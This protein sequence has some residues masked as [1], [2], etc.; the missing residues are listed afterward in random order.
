MLRS[1]GFISLLGF[2]ACNSNVPK[3]V[4]RKPQADHVVN[5]FY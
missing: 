1:R 3:V 5:T 2:D 4:G